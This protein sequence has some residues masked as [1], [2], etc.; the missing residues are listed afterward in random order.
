LERGLDLTDLQSGDVR[1]LAAVN[2]TIAR[3]RGSRLVLRANQTLGWDGQTIR[4]TPEKIYNLDVC[5]QKINRDAF[6]SSAMEGYT[7]ALLS[8]WCAAFLGL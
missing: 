8:K 5:L 6:G 7:Q 4:L 1:P 3:R 2:C